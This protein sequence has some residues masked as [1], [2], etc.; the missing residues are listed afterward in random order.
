MKSALIVVDMQ[1]DFVRKNGALSVEGGGETL[2]VIES[3]LEKASEKGIPVFFT[4]D[5]HSPDDPEF[6]RD[7]WPRHAVRNT[8]G[9]EIVEELSPKES[10]VEIIKNTEYD[11]FSG[12]KLG[13]KLS[14]KGVKRVY[15][16]GL[17]TDYCIK[18]TSLTALKLGFKVN[19]VI[20]GIKPVSKETGKEAKKE[21][22]KAGAKFKSS[23]QAL[24]ELG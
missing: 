19:V 14:K 12:T 22:E 10:N 8:K 13:E 9:A 17:A 15:L 6:E 1:N 24:V 5:W 23:E 3:L 20:D 7:G 4:M 21:M 18:F 2:P 11:K 16:C